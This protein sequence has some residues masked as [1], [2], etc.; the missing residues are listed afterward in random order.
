M[1]NYS[2]TA[3]LHVNLLDRVQRAFENWREA[4][5]QA[6]VFRTT[7]RELLSLSARELA[8]I[9]IS[10]SEINAIAYSAAYGDHA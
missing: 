10:R 5:A 2:V 9:G 1:A 3:P 4:R 8:D 7:R 6:K